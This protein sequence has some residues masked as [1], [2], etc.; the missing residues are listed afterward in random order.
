MAATLSA[1]RPGA[2][3]P[4]LSAR[5]S[6]GT[7]G[8]WPG[9]AAAALAAGL[10][11][12]ALQLARF[13][14]YRDMLLERNA[15]VNLTAIRDPA[16]VERR[17]FFDALRML[18]ALDAAVMSDADGQRATRLVDVGTGAGFP[19]LALK[20]ARP[21]LDVTLVEATGKKVAFLRGVIAALDLD[22]VV[23]VHARAED[24]GH[25]P[26]HRGAYRVVTARAVAPLAVLLELCVPLLRVGGVGLFPKGASIG[27][28]RRDAE[29]AARAV[30]AAIVDHPVTVDGARLVRVVKTGP[31]PGRL[32]RRAGIPAQ[33]PLGSTTATRRSAPRAPRATG[34][35]PLVSADAQRPR[36]DR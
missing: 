27:E 34:V 29:Y 30:G 3:K 13:D 32:P 33:E 28:E 19:G 22:G 20:I 18:P 31:T 6:C 25:D 21:D 9:L 15:R 35:A 8:A 1:A 14:A 23:A 36:T 17:L 24:L 11:L 2:A 4:D 26:R 10:P 7:D 12:G 16:D 5:D